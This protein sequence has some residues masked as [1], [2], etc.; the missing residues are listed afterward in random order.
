MDIKNKAI[1]AILSITI[2]LTVIAYLA[3]PTLTAFASKE[4]NSTNEDSV[5]LATFA[6]CESKEGYTFCKDKLFASCNQVPLEINDSIFYCN[7]KK[8]NASNLP[9]GET[10]HVQNWTDPRSRDF[11][12]AWASAA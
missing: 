9:L 1:L 6:I 5:K 11:I 8:H 10:Y 4:N 7:G 3:I 2:V 12:T